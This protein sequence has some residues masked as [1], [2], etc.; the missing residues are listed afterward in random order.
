MNDT[1]NSR[2]LIVG[3]G[4][5][6]TCL[7]WR[8]LE[9]GERFLVVDR[10]EPLTSSKV[11]AGLVTP[12]TGMR[13]S[14]N[15]RYDSLHP[16]AV[17]FYRE[18]ERVLN[19]AFYFDVP[20]VRLFKNENEQ[21][22]W[23]KRAGD[24]A[25]RPFVAEHDADGGRRSPVPLVDESV[26]A[27]PLGGFEQRDAGY[28]DT[29]AFLEAS[30]RHFESLGSWVK[31]EVT[32]EELALKPDAV[33]WRGQ[34]FSTVIFCRGWEGARSR[35]FSWAPFEPARG[36]VLSLRA[37]TNE[38]RIVNRGCWLLPRADGELKAGPTYELKFD[39]PNAPSSEAVADLENRVRSLLKVPFEITGSQ[40]AVRPIIKKRKALLGRHPAE[41]RIAFFNGLGSMGVL[42]APFMARM[43]AEH[44]LD[45]SPLE[46]EYD[47]QA[48]L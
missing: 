37:V 36:T 7:A 5:A 42:R 14:L 24:D 6:G 47:L 10:D 41:P 32:E 31:G 23:S 20:H 11:A 15:W 28:L 26:F 46:A 13:L 25:I 40:T 33:E 4:L 9:R 16:E 45:G 17:R 39:E 44:L 34:P 2:I 43:L 21:E 35:W 1:N 38:R 48:N 18:R 29:A 19:R 12:I 27:N 22:L 30:R 3:Q 8:L